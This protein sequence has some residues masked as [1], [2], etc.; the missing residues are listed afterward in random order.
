[1]IIIRRG[2]L[3]D[4][5]PFIELLSH[6][7]Q[8]MEHKEWLYLDSPDEVRE[9]MRN[10]TMSLWVA[11][12]GQQI[13]GA[14]DTLNPKLSSLNYGY[15]LGLDDIDL[16]RV[17]NMDT[18]VVHPDFRGHGLQKRLMQQ[19]EKELAES[20][21]HILLC[22]VHPHNHYSLNNLLSQGYTVCKTVKLYGSER[23]LM[24]KDLD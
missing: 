10:G 9:M 7:K 16:R 12:D 4:T 2:T 8:N 22:T 6:V 14:F 5:E 18:A 15:I 19:A 17:V 11:V 24:R 21:K 13:V 3:E 20:G 23:H 1:M